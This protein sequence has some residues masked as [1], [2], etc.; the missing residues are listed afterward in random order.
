[1]DNLIFMRALVLFDQIF[2]SII[3]FW[4]YL[5]ILYIFCNIAFAKGFT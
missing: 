5:F 4:R 2:L 1:M 3:D